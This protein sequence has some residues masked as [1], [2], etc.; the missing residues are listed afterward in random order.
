[1]YEVDTKELRIAMIKAGIDTIDGL[2]KAS[3]INRNTIS[4]VLN[5]TLYPSSNVMVA[6]VDALNLPS[7]QAGNIFFKEK[8]A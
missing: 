6:L 2:A 5:G 4:G 7:S 3:G 1:M 8:L